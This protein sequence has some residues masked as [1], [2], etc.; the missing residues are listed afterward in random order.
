MP[1]QQLDFDYL[2]ELVTRCAGVSTSPA[3]LVDDPAF[4]DMGVDSLGVLGIVAEVENHLGISLPDGTDGIQRPSD[5]I[6]L[7]NTR[8]GGRT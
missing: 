8:I 2:A 5:L 1:D 7:V 4:I 6:N 3:A